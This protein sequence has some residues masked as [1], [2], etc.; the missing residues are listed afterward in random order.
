MPTF[1]DGYNELFGKELNYTK[2]KC[3]KQMEKTC[4]IVHLLKEDDSTIISALGIK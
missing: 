1:P 4:S 2:T 3:I